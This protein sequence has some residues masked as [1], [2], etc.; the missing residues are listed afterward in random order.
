MSVIINILAAIGLIVLIS[1]FVYYL[2][3]YFQHKKV[4]TVMAQMNP[5]QDY[6]QNVGINCPDYWVNMGKVGDNIQCKN[7][8]NI[9][10]NNDDKCNNVY[11]PSIPKDKTWVYGNPNGLKTL[12]DSEK[13]KFL[14]TKSNADSYSRCEWINNCG[15]S[16]SVQG[17]WQGINEICN[18]P[19]PS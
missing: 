10:V 9:N 12:S 5:P 15:P 8:F 18:A 1:Y 2:Y 4:K 11:F 3:T 19:P 6:L 7:S 16:S 13:Y 17:V 14:K